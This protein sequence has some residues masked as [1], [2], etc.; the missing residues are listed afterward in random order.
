MKQLKIEE[1]IAIVVVLIVGAGF[2][3]FS[4]GFFGEDQN[5]ENIETNNIP[6]MEPIQ[7]NQELIITTTKPGEGVSAQTGDTVIVNY[8]GRLA[9]NNQEF[10]NSYD[11]GQPFPVTLGEN[12]V[13]AGWEQ[14]LLGSQAGETRTLMIPSDLGYGVRGT[15]GG[16]IPGNADLIFDIEILEVIPGNIQ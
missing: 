12:R 8:R 15:P 3:A 2:F 11:R 1:W 4:N 7:N 14:G 16:P 5:I 10:D 6:I 9:S 13:I